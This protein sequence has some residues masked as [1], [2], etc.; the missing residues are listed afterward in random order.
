MLKNCRLI[1]LGIIFM[2]VIGMIGMDHHQFVLTLV[3]LNL[4]PTFASS[5]N[6]NGSTIS[7]N[8]TNSQYSNA[9]NTQ[10]WMDPEKNLKIHSTSLF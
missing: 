8:K 4:Q 5:N 2:F 6:N 1:I 9:N 3:K 10:E 7:V